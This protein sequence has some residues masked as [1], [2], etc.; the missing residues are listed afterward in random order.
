MNVEHVYGLSIRP[1]TGNYGIVI[2]LGTQLPF[3]ARCCRSGT[4]SEIPV[5]EEG[6]APNNQYV[7]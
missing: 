4:S 7:R 3:L 1:L 2:A 6:C 5:S